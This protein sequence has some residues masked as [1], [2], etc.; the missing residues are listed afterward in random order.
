VNWPSNLAEFNF[1]RWAYADDSEELKLLGDNNELVILAG[2]PQDAVAL[3][4]AGHTVIEKWLREKTKAYLARKFTA[5]DAD[6]LKNLICSICNQ[7]TLIE[8]ADK[9]VA[10]IIATQNVVLPFSRQ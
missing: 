8:I 1:I 9:I 7:N 10:D 2:V 6:D 4:I 3:R 5:D